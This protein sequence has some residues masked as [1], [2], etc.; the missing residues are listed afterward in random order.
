[1]IKQEDVLFVEDNLARV[2]IK[3]SVHIERGM[4]DLE[5]WIAFRVYLVDENNKVVEVVG[6]D[7]NPQVAEVE[8]MERLE[9]LGYDLDAV[10]TASGEYAARWNEAW[11][12]K[13]PDEA[14]ERDAEQAAATRALTERLN[15]TADWRLGH[16]EPW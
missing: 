4:A 16:D 8:A 1:M 3:G 7:D 12:E 13:Y 11:R 2:G 10:Y 6:T 14:A 5:G 9:E 15:R